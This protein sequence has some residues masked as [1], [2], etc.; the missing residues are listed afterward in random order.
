MFGEA[1]DYALEKHQRML[2][3]NRLAEGVAVCVSSALV[4]SYPLNPRHTSIFG[5]FCSGHFRAF[6]LRSANNL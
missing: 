6:P 1:V 2:E 3:A 4:R 5:F